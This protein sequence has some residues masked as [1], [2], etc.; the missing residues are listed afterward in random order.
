M[1]IALSRPA[2]WQ[3]SRTHRN[4]MAR[5]EA[6]K[7]PPKRDIIDVTRGVKHGAHGTMIAMCQHLGI[8]TGELLSQ[9]RTSTLLL[10]RHTMCWVGVRRCQKTY[11]Q[12]GKLLDRDHTTVLHGVRKI[13]RLIAER[14][15]TV[16]AD[17]M[18]AAL[19]LNRELG[20]V[21]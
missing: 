12:I 3:N 4:A 8:S 21:Q 11:A 10:A 9:R 17:P 16:P 18:S 1:T 14:G 13:D 20:G 7:Q 2:A 15:L 5:V 6:A 19:Y